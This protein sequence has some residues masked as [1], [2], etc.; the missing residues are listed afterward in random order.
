MTPKRYRPYDCP[1]SAG[2]E[3]IMNEEALNTSLR[4]FLKEV[5]VT[6]QREIETAVRAAAQQGKLKS[7]SVRAK[8][9]LTIGELGLTHT[10]EHDIKV[11]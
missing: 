5:G 4:K 11:D 2:L 9:V 7:G 3:T 6:S 1:K 8:M 10:V